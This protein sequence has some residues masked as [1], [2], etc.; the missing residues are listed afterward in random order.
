MIPLFICLFIFDFAWHGFA[1][2]SFMENFYLLLLILFC[3][4]DDVDDD[5]VDDDVYLEQLQYG[6]RFH[7]IY[8]V[9]MS[10]VKHINPANEA[11]V[12]GYKNSKHTCNFFVCL[13]DLSLVC[14]STGHD[15][16][17]HSLKI[18]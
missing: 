2:L 16:A 9:Y 17:T 18:T 4:D 15:K 5:D 14:L 7:V 1:F 8:S 3:D 10:Y 11:K 12:N 6:K 13:F